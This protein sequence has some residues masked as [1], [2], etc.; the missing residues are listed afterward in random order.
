MNTM[1]ILTPSYSPDL[2]S[3]IRLHESVLRNTGESTRHHVIVPKR[4]LSVFRA[5]SSPRLD[6][7]SESEFLP[8]GFVTTDGVAALWR[9]IPIAPRS[10]NCSAINLQKPWPPVRGWILQQILKLSASTK[11]NCDAVVVIDSDVVLVRPM[12]VETFIRD[13]VVRL[14]EKPDGITADLSRHVLWTKTAYDLLGL[15][16][17]PQSTFPDYVGGIVSWDPQV[18][19]GCLDR[20]QQVCGS[21][22]ASEVAGRLHFSEFILYGT[23]LRHFGTERQGS[24][25]AASTLCHSYWSPSPLSEEDAET[26]VAAYPPEDLAVH[27]QSNS[28][29]PSHVIESV[30]AGLAVRSRP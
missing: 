28:G 6:V 23:Y 24:F 14:Y 29:T 20:I 26:F 5:I 18:L 19:Q 13:G 17:R 9:R 2:P 10:I 27:V 30:V 8:K 11:L 15:P 16:W 12:P 4:D 25:G 21:D 7:W 22:W 3:F 1:A